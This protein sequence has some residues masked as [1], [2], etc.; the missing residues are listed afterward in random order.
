MC[1]TKIHKGTYT[2]FGPLVLIIFYNSVSVMLRVSCEQRNSQL[3]KRYVIYVKYSPLIMVDEYPFLFTREALEFG[4]SY[5]IS[6]RICSRCLQ[7]RIPFP[8]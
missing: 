1:H 8:H 2:I 7:S 3:R 5:E 6:E 4:T